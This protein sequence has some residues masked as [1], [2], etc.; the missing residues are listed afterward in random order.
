[1]KHQLGFREFLLAT[2]ASAASFPALSQPSGPCFKVN[3]ER[4]TQRVFINSCPEDLVVYMCYIWS[5]VSTP[6]KE[7]SCAHGKPVVAH[8]QL[9]TAGG[10]FW[11][12]KDREA[13]VQVAK[14]QVAQLEKM[15]QQ[16]ATTTSGPSLREQ[17]TLLKSVPYVLFT[18]KSGAKHSDYTTVRGANGYNSEVIFDVCRL[19]NFS[20]GTCVPDPIKLWKQGG[21]PMTPK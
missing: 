6:D 11:G 10:W 20:A 5:G 8:N 3:E 17:I 2:V 4:D 13:A 14:D 12:P 16:G 19:S 18:L 9:H 15:A 21:S 7:R 1:M